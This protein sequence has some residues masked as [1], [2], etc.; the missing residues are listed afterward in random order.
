MSPDHWSEF[1]NP[2]TNGI[3]GVKKFL[4]KYGD[5]SNNK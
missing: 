5:Y 4:G 2:G 3:D 1:R